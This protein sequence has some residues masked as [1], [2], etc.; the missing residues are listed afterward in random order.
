[1]FWAKRGNL[2][3][4]SRHDPNIHAS[5]PNATGIRIFYKLLKSRQLSSKRLVITTGFGSFFEC[6][7]QTHL[8]KI[9]LSHFLPSSPLTFFVSILLLEAVRKVGVSH[10][11]SR[12]WAESR[13]ERRA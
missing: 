11:A 10:V 9:N 3:L 1:M 7:G 12:I 13:R 8:D 5:C 2:V 4:L 6:S